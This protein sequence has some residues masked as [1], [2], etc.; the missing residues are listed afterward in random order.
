MQ[1]GWEVGNSHLRSRNTNVGTW[2]FDALCAHTL[3]RN[4]EVVRL[5][6]S[7]ELCCIWF[8]CGLGHQVLRFFVISQEC[9]GVF[10]ILKQASAAS[11]CI[12]FNSMSS[13][14]MLTAGGA[15]ILDAR[16]YGRPNSLHWRLMLVGCQYGTCSLH[17][18]VAWN[19]KLCVCAYSVRF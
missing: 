9:S 4:A 11:L 1:T 3:S 5:P 2:K 16:L 18:E 6:M 15:Q 13:N 14:S 19:Y 7:A 12:P 10:S 8:E 17:P